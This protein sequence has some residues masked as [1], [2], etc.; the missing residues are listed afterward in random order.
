VK[1][2]LDLCAGVLAAVVFVLADMDESLRD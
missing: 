2:D 1:E